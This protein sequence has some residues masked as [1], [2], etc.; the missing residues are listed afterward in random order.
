M[1]LFGN[2][3]MIR[4]RIQQ[5]IY[6]LRKV[7]DSCLYTEKITKSMWSDR[8]KVAD[9][10]YAFKNKNITFYNLNDSFKP[11]ALKSSMKRMSKNGPHYLQQ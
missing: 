5:F 9:H 8:E 4:R 1:E 2:K 11:Q 3:R 6:L 7:L 10:Y